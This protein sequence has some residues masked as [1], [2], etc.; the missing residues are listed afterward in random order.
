MGHGLVGGMVEEFDD[1]GFVMFATG[2]RNGVE[3]FIFSING[4]VGGDGHGRRGGGGHLL[5]AGTDC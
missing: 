5:L 2:S 4:I 3:G 1:D